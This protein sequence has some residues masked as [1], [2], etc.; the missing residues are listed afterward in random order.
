MIR[1]VRLV[2]RNALV[3]RH[4]WRGSL[5]TSFLQPTLFL[6]AI[7][8]GVG[9]LVDR[10]GVPLPEGVGFLAF[11]APGLLAAACMQTG[12]FE[13]SWSILAKISWQR[14][15]DA[16]FATPMRI[17][18]IVI[19]ELAWL[20]VRLT[21]VAT[22]FV[23]VMAA[24]RVP[25]S[26]LVVL[27]I[28]AAVITGLAFASVIMAFAATIKSNGNAFNVIFRFILTPLFLF[29]G[30]FFP[31]SRLPAALGTVAAFTPLYHGV[32][33]TRALTL[34]TLGS[35][36]WIVHVG[37]LTIM[38]MAGAAAAVWTFDRKLRV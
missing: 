32:A 10:G 35:A 17:V 16:I 22:A 7:G 18:D 37:Y 26:P 2:Q 25:R 23:L 1:A 15:Y 13:S 36:E 29:S 19:G 3:Y 6:V 34:G 30:T 21:T 38:L 33:L 14:N 4:T 20:A 27:A 8:I 28:P 31:I 11:L 5:F 24:F 12:T 9:T